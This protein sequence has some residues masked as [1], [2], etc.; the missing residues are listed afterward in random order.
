VAV[1]VPTG[2]QTGNAVPVLL[3]VGSFTSPAGATISIT[4]N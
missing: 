1:Q 3:Q 2:I 4:A